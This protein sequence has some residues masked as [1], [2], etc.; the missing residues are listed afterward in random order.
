MNKIESTKISLEAM[1]HSCAHVLEAAV[2]EMFPEEQLGVGPIIQDGFYYDFLLPRTLIPE[3]LPILEEKMRAFIAQDYHF[4]RKEV[5]IPEAK[6]ILTA[7]KQPFKV[8]LVEEIERGE[9]ATKKSGTVSFYKTG[10]LVDLCKGWHVESTKAIG[11]FK[12]L[13]IAGAYWKSDS[14]RVALQRIYA[15]CWPTSTELDAYLALREEAHQRDHR[16]LGKQMDLFSFHEEGPGFIFW[17]PN[18]L[19][20]YEALV[21]WWRAL[22]TRAGYEEVKTPYLLDEELWHRSGH[23]QNYKDNMYFTTIDK[24]RFAVKP[25]NCPGMILIYKNRQHSYRDLPMRM[26]ELGQVHRN[27]LS[28]VLHGLFRV[29]AFTQDDAHIFCR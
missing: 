2:L 24:R 23:W 18:G 13:S 29:R 1:R 9:R 11:P 17:H 15:T 22:H 6:K 14:T 21:S 20:V 7:A 10:P 4:E 16:I 28:G 8:E 19:K 5:G 12:L 25:M 26:S 3:D 27:E